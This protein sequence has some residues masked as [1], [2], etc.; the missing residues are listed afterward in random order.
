MIVCM[1]CVGVVLGFG[2]SE[3]LQQRDLLWR[4]LL[5]RSGRTVDDVAIRY[6]ELWLERMRLNPDSADYEVL[7]SRRLVQQKHLERLARMMTLDE[8][9]ANDLPGG[10][11]QYP[12][13]DRL[14]GVDPHLLPNLQSTGSEVE[15]HVIFVNC[16]NIEVSYHWVDGSGTQHYYGHVM[17]DAHAR[18][19]TYEGHIWVVKNR[20][21]EDLAVFRATAPVAVAIVENG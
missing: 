20:R 3:R 7:E 15:T 5:E 9:I 1:L 10:C 2:L 11:D 13:W 12:E 16:T 21:G 19:H 17:P 8:P 4:W 14:R 18:Q 6:G